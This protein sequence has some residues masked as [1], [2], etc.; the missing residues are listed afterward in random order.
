MACKIVHERVSSQKPPVRKIFTL[1]ENEKT[2]SVCECVFVCVRT[3]VCVHVYVWGVCVRVK[4][5]VRDYEV[6][7]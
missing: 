4:G 5:I 1:E 3:R 7:M 2:G 6:F